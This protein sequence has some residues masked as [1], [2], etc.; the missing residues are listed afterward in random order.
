MDN[1]RKGLEKWV[2]DVVG[3]EK[4]EMGKERGRY[5]AKGRGKT[6]KKIRVKGKN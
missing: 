4:Y 3:K 2:K 5:I 1:R 6:R